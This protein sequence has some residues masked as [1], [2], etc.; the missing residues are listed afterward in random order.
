MSKKHT[1]RISLSSYSGVLATFRCYSGNKFPLKCDL[2]IDHKLSSSE[3]QIFNRHNQASI[4]STQRMHA[5]GHKF[6]R[7]FKNKDTPP[8]WKWTGYE[9]ADRIDKFAEK[10]K[11]IQITGCDDSYYSS[12]SIVFVPHYDAK[13]NYYWG[14]T[15]IIVTQND[16]QPPC[17]FFLYPGHSKAFENLLHNINTKCHR[18]RKD[19]RD[20]IKFSWHCNSCKRPRK[21]A[22]TCRRCSETLCISCMK[23][24]NGPRCF[25]NML[26][27]N[28]I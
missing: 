27:A 3:K 25:A 17:E 19:H 1:H 28:S 14:T 16:G 13:L 11:E 15:V 22:K 12:S 4:A 26:N 5:L 23:N 9:L 10:H 7:A 20:K 24:H 21:Q 18:S 8:T 6:F 2:T